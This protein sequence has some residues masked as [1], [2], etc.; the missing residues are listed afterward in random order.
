MPMAETLMLGPG[1][2][3][4][5]WK[6]LEGKPWLCWVDSLAKP[7]AWLSR[8]RWAR[9]SRAHVWL[10][11]Q[12]PW[13]AACN[14]DP[15]LCT[16]GIFLTNSYQEC[17]PTCVWKMAETIPP[18]YKFHTSDQ[19]GQVEQVWKES[20]FTSSPFTCHLC[21]HPA[22]PPTLPLSFG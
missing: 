5:L 20:I 3:V 19:K 8:G 11:S 9:G 1:S 7:C 15:P 4:S 18:L 6:A 22:L 16:S 21:P 2:Q 17:A 12:W 14:V 10:F 13:L